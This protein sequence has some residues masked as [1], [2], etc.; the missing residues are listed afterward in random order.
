[1]VKNVKHKERS[2]KTGPVH[3]CIYNIKTFVVRKRENI[4]WF[5]GPVFIILGIVLLLNDLPGFGV[6]M[7]VVGI[8]ICFGWYISYSDRVKLEARKK[9]TEK[10]MLKIYVK[11]KEMFLSIPELVHA[12]EKYLDLAE[13]EFL[14]GVFAPFWDEIERATE[15]LAGCQRCLTDINKNVI[16]Y[17]TYGEIK[18]PE[19]KSRKAMSEEITRDIKRDINYQRRAP[20]DKHKEVWRR[21]KEAKIKA[22]KIDSLPP[23]ELPLGKL[24][25]LRSTSARLTAIV[26]ESQKDFQF[27]TIYEQRKTNKILIAG[28]NTLESAIYGLGDAIAFSLN[29]LSNN[30]QTSLNDLLEETAYQTSVLNDIRSGIKQQ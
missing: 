6:L 1:M 11:S 7:I 5:V 14:E 17:S 15:T 12:T 20:S 3:L 18:Q 19:K 25:D 26:R 27:A 8:L 29:E 30:L 9:V 16:T 22:L 4:L 23:F 21:I 28:F 13:K 2:Q 24:P 10:R